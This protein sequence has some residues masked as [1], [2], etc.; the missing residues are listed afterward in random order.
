MLNLPRKVTVKDLAA[1][2]EDDNGK[3]G[4]REFHVLYRRLWQEAIDNQG[5]P[6]RLPAS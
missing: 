6:P 2:D 1:V 4:Y 3:L 5:K